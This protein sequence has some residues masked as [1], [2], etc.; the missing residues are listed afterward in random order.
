M[1]AL[2][3]SLMGIDQAVLLVGVTVLKKEKRLAVCLDFLLGM[4]KANGK[5]VNWVGL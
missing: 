2:M 1:V 5:A 4:K 3:V